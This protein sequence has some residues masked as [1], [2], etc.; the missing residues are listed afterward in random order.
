MKKCL[1][2][3]LLTLLLLAA[4]ACSR[5]NGAAS[6]APAEAS[7]APA[8][9]VY[10]NPLTGEVTEKDLTAYCP[11]AVML[12]TAHAALPQ[13]GNS[14]AD[15]Y[16]EV[17]EEGGITR[18][19]AFYQ[20][21]TDVGW[22]GPIRSTRPYFVRL[23]VGQDA[24]LT[25]CGGSRKA[26]TIIQ[27]YMKKA[28]FNDIDALNHGTNCGWSWFQRSE[29]RLEA[30]YALEHTLYIHSDKLQDFLK[31][32]KDTIR[33]KHKGD[34]HEPSLLFTEDGTPEDGS[35]AKEIKVT[36]S[37]VKNTGF[38]YDDEKGVY[39]V[40]EFDEPYMDERADKQV[41]VENVL[42][43]QTDISVNEASSLGHLTV[44][45]T[46]KGPGYYAS[47]GKFIPITWEKKD[48]ESQ[49]HFFKEDGTE[50]QV[51]VGKTYICIVDK[52]R[53]IAIDGH[54]EAKPSDADESN[55]EVD[56]MAEVG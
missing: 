28:D 2:L 6:S 25:H 24:L 13:S 53:D 16:Y 48:V 33:R 19:M 1:S 9:T 21:V 55:A 7:S 43:L 11:I 23:A 45:L 52:S 49:Q 22:I 42:L 46:G 14:K 37:S 41:T 10:R 36:M 8:P 17:P 51:G 20:D 40:S 18:I 30:G 27:K 44:I 12:N 31:E 4:A 34:S 56:N 39:K 47:G 29:E 38:Q 15:M 32:K 35:F 50:L 54:I 3:L 26:Y 5:G